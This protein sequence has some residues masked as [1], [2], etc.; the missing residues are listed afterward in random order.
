MSI[1]DGE[2]V[3][4]SRIMLL[5][6][7]LLAVLKFTVFNSIPWILVFS[8]IWLPI[9]AFVVILFATYMDYRTVNLK[10]GSYR[11]TIQ[12]KRKV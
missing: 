5:L 6:V 10:F 12:R 4:D 3:V 11:K 1:K 7:V 9:F 2:I 8:P